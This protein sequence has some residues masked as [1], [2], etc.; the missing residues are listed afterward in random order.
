MSAPA[1]VR[2]SAE[3]TGYPGILPVMQFSE[4]SA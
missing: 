1:F 4:D 2:Q 3:I